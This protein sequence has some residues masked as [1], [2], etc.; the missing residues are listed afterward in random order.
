MM[1][2]VILEEISIASTDPWPLRPRSGVPKIPD[3]GLPGSLDLSW[4]T[5]M[6]TVELVPAALTV[7]E[8][9]YKLP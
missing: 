3:I 8:K 4:I 2:W 5:A 1:Y 6:S 9:S 7:E